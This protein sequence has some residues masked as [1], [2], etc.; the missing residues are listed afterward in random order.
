LDKDKAIISPEKEKYFLA[1]IMLTALIIRLNAA[2]TSSYFVDEGFSYYISLENFAKIFRYSMISEPHPPLYY[3]FLKFLTFFSSEPMFFRLTSVIFSVFSLYFIYLTAKLLFGSRVALITILLYSVSYEAWLS[4]IQARSGSLSILLV[5]AVY[6]ILIGMIT[7]PE[8]FREKKIVILFFIL[9]ILIPLIHYLLI[10]VVIINFLCAILFIKDKNAKLIS[11]GLFLIITLLILT[12]GLLVIKYNNYYTK[13]DRSMVSS[14]GMRNIII[15]SRFTSYATGFEIPLFWSFVRNRALIPVK[16]HVFIKEI[17]IPLAS[18]ILLFASVLNI[19][20]NRETSNRGIYALLLLFLI[21]YIGILAIIYAGFQSNYQLRYYF[22]IVPLF[23]MIFSYFLCSAKT[24]FMKKLSVVFIIYLTFI[25]V[26]T[27]LIEFRKDS[28][29]WT[30]DWKSVAWYIHKNRHDTDMILGYIPYSFMGFSMEYFPNDGR[31]R[32]GTKDSYALH[33]QPENSYF[34]KGGLN[35]IPIEASFIPD[36][37][38]KLLKG[39]RFFLIFNQVE[40]TDTDKLV[41][42]YFFTKY[43]IV[44]GVYLENYSNLGSIAVFIM[45]DK[46]R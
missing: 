26:Y 25:G 10:L 28:F 36:V 33:F 15:F 14:I 44:D 19:W 46:N 30:Q 16:S 13:I 9:N 5:S 31:W 21:P 2:L 12:L 43:R 6:Y 20:K 42:D 24:K 39:K 1:G 41:K 29:F 40:D 22:F 27:G 18:I 11:T 32:F 38:D 7:Q 35:Q 37:T 17:I 3:F 4:Q 45:E 34:E 8:K 23:L